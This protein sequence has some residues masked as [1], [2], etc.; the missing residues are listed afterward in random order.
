VGVSP[1][2]LT[3]APEAVRERVALR[4]LQEVVSLASDGDYEATPTA[5]GVLSVDASRSCEDSLLQLIREVFSAHDT[6]P[7]ALLWF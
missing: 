6:R 2:S 3:G 4:C 1:D 7:C 5:G